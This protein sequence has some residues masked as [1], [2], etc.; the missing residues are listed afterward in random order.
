MAA[1]LEAQERNARV[2]VFGSASLLRGERNFIL[3]GEAFRSEYIAGGKAGLR[4]TVDLNDRWSLEGGYRFGNNNLRIIEE[5][6]TATAERRTFGIHQHQVT[7][8]VLR[9]LNSTKSN[10]NL[11]VALGGGLMRFSPSE[12]ARARAASEFVN[13]PERNVRAD[14]EWSL[15]FGT[16][17]EAKLTPRWGIRID[18]L[19][20]IV[21]IPRFGLPRTSPGGGVDFYPVSGIMHNI[22]PSLGV[23]YRWGDPS[24]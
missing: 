20:H 16:G 11:F 1:S 22:E 13:N 10:I 17:L 5:L 3:H 18:I 4:G 12:Q 8:T 24:S 19:D 6:G 7:A 14:N 23:V 2:S 9:R 21:G 15:H